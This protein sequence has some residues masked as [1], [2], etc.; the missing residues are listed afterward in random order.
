MLYWKDIWE[1]IRK[2]GNNNCE[3]LII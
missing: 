3:I 2:M 1:Q